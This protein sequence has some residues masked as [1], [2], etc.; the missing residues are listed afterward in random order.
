MKKTR[1]LMAML[2][3]LA[4][5]VSLV[6]ITASAAE[7]LTSS[8]DFTTL[9]P[10]QDVDTAVAAIKAAGAVDAGN[11][12]L[13]GNFGYPVA[14]PGGYMGEGWF[15]QKLEAPAGETLTSAKLELGYWLVT[16]A[17]TQGY[18]Q[19]HVSSD[20][21]T[22]AMVKEY[23]E[24]NGKAFE[25]SEIKDT[26]DLP[27][28]AGQTAIY[29]KVVVQHWE[30]WEGAAISSSKL[31]ATAGKDEPVVTDPTVSYINFAAL[32][33]SEDLNTAIATIKAAGAVDAHN[34]KL[35]GNFG[36]PLANPG[37]YAGEGYVVQKVSAP[38][39]KSLSGAKLELAYWLTTN[40]SQG[41]VRVLASAD[42][43]NYTQI[44]E[45]NEGNGKSFENSVQNATVDIP[46]ADGQ[47][48][49]YV[50][51]VVQHWDTWEGAAL[52]S[53]KLTATVSGAA[54]SNPGTGDIVATVFALMAV[55]AAGIVV[56]TK[57]IR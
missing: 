42:G 19:V 51:I 25:N 41:Y 54:P 49:V 46:V 13:A 16:P 39:G 50:Q 14:N 36:Y 17:A 47:K 30:T 37:G 38:E 18:V 48:D 26:I 34:L 57:K 32:A 56:T 24:G 5:L 15:I 43:V 22:Y 29:V 53:S 21:T 3:M 55:C 10:S 2:V 8:I 27:V 40:A 6:S 44:K 45:F 12:K 4:L 11:L 9:T 33:G 28:S 20:G 31:T 1:S 52:E 35:A 7:T 23:K